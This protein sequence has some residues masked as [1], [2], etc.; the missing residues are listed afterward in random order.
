MKTTNN[1]MLKKLGL[2]AVSLGFI[3]FAVA[4]TSYIRLVD[5]NRTNT[6][7][8]VAE[9]EETPV[10]EPVAEEPK[11]E[12]EIRLE[13]LLK[14]LTAKYNQLKDTQIAGT[15]I[16]AIVGAVFGALVAIIPALLNRKN[17]K[18]A[19]LEVENAKKVINENLT[20]I[21]DNKE[22]FSVSCK[23]FDRT[24]EIITR[25]SKEIEK[26]EQTLETIT[27]INI[28]MA[29][30]NNDLKEICITMINNTK[31]LVLNGVAENINKKFN[32]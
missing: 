20:L 24:M 2:I 3:S 31:E 26:L 18:N 5:Q 6:L 10:V 13:E 11:S 30:A 21:E 8:V 22:K 7:L 1:S 19:L 28:D 32:K 4:S 14:Q 15:T 29:K 17:I 27:E 25:A 12:F 16:G 23:N 9:G